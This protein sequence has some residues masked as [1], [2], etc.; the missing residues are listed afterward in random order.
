MSV[1]FDK[2]KEV[3]QKLT[4]QEKEA[5]EAGKT[6][7]STSQSQ[8][9]PGLEGDMEPQPVKTHLP[10]ED[11][12]YQLYRAAGKL[13][14]KRALITGGD[15]GIGRAVAILY[16]MEG[17]NVAITHLPEELEDALHTKEQV[18]KNGGRAHLI[19]KDLRS[20][21]AAED[22]VERAVAAL[23]GLDIL[24]NNAAYELE[25]DDISQI[26]EEQYHR[27]I[28]TNLT[29]PFFLSK[30]ALRHLGKRGTIINTVSVDGYVGP[31]SHLDYSTSKGGLIAFTRNLANQQAKNGIR[32]NAVAPGP[33]WTPF[34][35]AALKQ[36]SQKTMADGTSMK[37]LGQPV[38]VATSY[39]FLGS[40]DSSY[41]T[42]QVIHVNG[43]MATVS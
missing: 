29:A 31:Q 32:V 17:A 7:Y 9:H 41:I 5:G 24:I 10:T 22:V 12:G 43:G 27:T 16:A 25:Q 30:H 2:A 23:G 34:L 26:S 20:K 14:G 39:V 13:Q 6:K 33:I 38:E 4:G 3:A 1:A 37:R 11:G 18:E 8:P 40:Q 21:G 36:E 28:E 42:G 19:S 35:P 15:S